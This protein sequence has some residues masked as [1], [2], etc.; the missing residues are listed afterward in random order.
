MADAQDQISPRARIAWHV[1]VYTLAVLLFAFF[2]DGEG[3]NEALL[4]IMVFS[5]PGLAAIDVLRARQK[6]RK[7]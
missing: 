5:Y 7:G 3:R 6:A 2:S 4:R 1:A